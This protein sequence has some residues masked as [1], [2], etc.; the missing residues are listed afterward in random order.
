M[1]IMVVCVAQAQAGPLVG[2][3]HKTIRENIAYIVGQGAWSPHH[4]AMELG[5]QV[6]N[7]ETIC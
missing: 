2:R 7:A 6:K 1:L 3:A 5:Q 4:G